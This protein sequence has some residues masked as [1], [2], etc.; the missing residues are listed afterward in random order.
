MD[1]RIGYGWKNPL[2]GKLQASMLSFCLSGVDWSW[3]PRFFK[4]NPVYWMSL[5][6]L[7]QSSLDKIRGKLFN[8]LWVGNLAGDKWHLASWKSLSLPRALCG[9]GIKNLGV[10]NAAL[11]AKSLWRSFFSTGLWGKVVK[12]K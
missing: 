2:T 4:E 10:F 5:F 12:E 9:W 7:P 8:F 6:T 11:Y 1:L 3:C